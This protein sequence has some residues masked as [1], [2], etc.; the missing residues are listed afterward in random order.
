MIL[1]RGADENATFG[2]GRVGDMSKAVSGGSGVS[3]SYNR[4]AG[5]NAAQAAPGAGNYVM[6]DA[7]ERV[8]LSQLRNVSQRSFVQS[9]TQ[10]VDVNYQQNLRIVK[11]KAF[12]PAYL[13][14]A[15]A[16][17][18]MAQFLSQSGNV[19]VALR[20]IA[21]QTGPDG[22]DAEFKPAEFNDIKKDMDLE[23]G[24]PTAKAPAALPMAMITPP[25]RPISIAWALPLAL[26]VLALAWRRRREKRG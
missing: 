19:T 6:N 16:N 10:W 21:I 22:Q 2:A 18:R 9:G 5:M 13:Q 12:S 14:L 20:N 17:P 23:L 3:Q 1:S 11:V 4:K 7:G 8:Q 25:H 24:V 15:N 26:P